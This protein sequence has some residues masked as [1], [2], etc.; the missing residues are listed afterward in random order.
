[1]VADWAEVSVLT[2]TAQQYG[3]WQGT[4]ARGKLLMLDGGGRQP[5]IA[6]Q[7]AYLSVLSYRMHL[8]QPFDSSCLES[9]RHNRG[10]RGKARL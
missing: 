7:I 9:Q 8:L 4:Q 2:D 10:Y 6:F 5:R 3:E 1:M